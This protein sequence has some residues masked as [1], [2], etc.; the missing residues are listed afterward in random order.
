MMQYFNKEDFSALAT[1]G[2]PKNVPVL[3][4]IALGGCAAVFTVNFT[5]PIELMKTRLQVYG[6]VAP[7]TMIKEEGLLCFWKGIQPAWG[8]ESFYASIKIG[9]YG[10]IR[11]ALGAS[12][13]DAPFILKFLAGSLSGSIGAAVGNPFDVMKTKMQ[14]NAGKNVPVATLAKDFMREQGIGGFYRGLSANV[15]RACV[16]NGTKMAC[17]D[18]FKGI[19]TD[20]TGWGRKDPRGQALSSVGAGFVMTCTVAPFDMI[21]TQLMNQPVDKKIYSG[22]LDAGKSFIQ[23]EGFFSLWRG[24]IPIWARFAPSAVIQLL[25]FETLL[26]LTGYANL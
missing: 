21:R 8:R 5:H 11:D 18:K 7:M 17:Y 9:G 25:T 12:G 16:L 22:F 4:S 10:P 1:A 23:K 19:V 15:S 13:K 26:T 3:A 24:F 14:A 20:T 6:K 2:A